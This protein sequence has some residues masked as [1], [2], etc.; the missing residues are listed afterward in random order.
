MIVML[1]IGVRMCG[2]KGMSSNVAKT[3]TYK[4]HRNYLPRNSHQQTH[5]TIADQV[6]STDKYK[7]LG[8][9]FRK[10]TT[11]N[12]KQKFFDKYG[13]EGTSEWLLLAL[14]NFI[15]IS[16]YDWM[17]FQENVPP[18]FIKLLKGLTKF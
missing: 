2:I 1:F 7:Q 8:I 6:M 4:G 14:M 16:P 15:D 18:N 12:A 9:E 5:S 11:K 10:L 13:I 3:Q 17:H